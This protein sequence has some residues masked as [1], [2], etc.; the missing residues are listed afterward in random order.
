MRK[1]LFNFHFVWKFFLLPGYFFHSLCL[2]QRVQVYV[3]D[4][5]F[6]STD[7]QLVEEFSKLVQDEF[8]ISLM[9]ELNYFFGIKIKQLNEGSFVYQTKYCNNL[10]NRFGM[11]DA[12]SI[13]TPMATNG[14][15]EKNE[16]GKDIDVKKYRGMIGSLLYLTASRSD[17]SH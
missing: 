4:I 8:E 13:D 14:N 2:L 1:Y 6:R 17:I 9:E 7:M 16:N 15:L 5:I 11:E 12:K 10:L 3:D